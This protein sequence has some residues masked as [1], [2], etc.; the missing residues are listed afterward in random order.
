M[1]QGG[2]GGASPLVTLL[3]DFGD[4]HYVAQMKG[5]VRKVCPGADVVDISHEVR[6]GAIK[7]GAFL[8][9]ASV[10]YF[11]KAFHV[12]V[13]D[14]GVGTDRSAI[15]VTT[16]NGALVGP[17]NGLLIPAARRLGLL[18][19]VEV[20][21]DE[22]MLPEVTDT[23]HGRDVFAPVAAHVA[24]GVRPDEVGQMA[25]GYLEEALQA[26]AKE[27]RIE[28]EVLHVD[29]FG[30]CVLSAWGED[31]SEVHAVGDAVPLEIGGG[32]GPGRGKSE[33]LPMVRTFAD[34]EEGQ[35]GV[36]VGSSGFLEVVV[37]GGSAAEMF[38]LDVGSRVTVGLG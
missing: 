15:L 36:D 5:V 25:G 1:A 31:V 22:L 20:T 29:R 23:F 32:V 7:Q 8:L 11:P 21:N 4:S 13:V 26:P 24:R 19:V 37:R 28:A 16:R 3:T 34:L 12:G 35:A 10:P 27:D 33:E 2:P 18:E 17:D 9:W 30:D 6:P 14:P 38:G